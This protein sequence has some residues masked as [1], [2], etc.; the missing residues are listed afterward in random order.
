M[1]FTVNEGFNEFNTNYVNLEPEKSKK[2]KI[3]RDW[4]LSQLEIL[5]NKVP[6]FPDLYE[7]KHIQ[8]GSFARKTKIR[9]LDDIDL[10]LTFSANGSTY[11]TE[12]SNNYILKV[13]ESATILRKFC[14]TDFTLNS[15]K[16]VNKLVASLNS[17]EQYKSAE[18]H[19]KQEAATLN[20]R[21]YE[22]NFDLV[23]AFYTDKD[24]YLIPNG[25]GGWKATDPRIDQNRL[26]LINQKHNAKIL[27]I[28][29]ILKYW[30][31]RA[32]MP[33]ISSYL[34]EN[35]ILNFFESKTEISDYIDFNIS[36][37][38][39]DLSVS[40]FQQV[41]DPKGFQ[42]N[43]NDLHIEDKIRISEKAKSTYKLSLEAR[44]LEITEKDQEKAINKW[45]EIFGDDFPKYY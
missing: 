38:W 42:Q 4:L 31:I 6:D 39:N 41:K 2:A 9:P 34:L 36:N 32:K 13:P 25:I 30:N 14:N 35:L 1:V 37:F 20:L 40:I 22:W 8:F 12:S 27:Q 43:L 10:I 28:I 16:I 29:R 5:Q 11:L 44:E 19:R 23:P 21:S 18:I 3:S 24:F 15:I 45:R 33:T 26:T 17:I 7:E